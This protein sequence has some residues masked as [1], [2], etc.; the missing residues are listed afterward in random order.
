MENTIKIT[1]VSSCIH[2][3]GANGK[4][5][6]IKFIKKDGS[7]RTMNCRLGV[8]KYLKGGTNTTSHINKYLT[9]FSINDGNYRNVNMETVTSISGCGEV[10]QF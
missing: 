10:F 9:V 2:K 7:N 3:V 5:F 4:V 8:K 6:G 1:K